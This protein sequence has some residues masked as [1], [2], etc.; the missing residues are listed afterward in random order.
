MNTSEIIVEVHP[1]LICCVYR[2]P[3]GLLFKRKYI[4]YSRSASIAE[5]KREVRVANRE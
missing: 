2:M 1:N 4:G 5:F 3:S